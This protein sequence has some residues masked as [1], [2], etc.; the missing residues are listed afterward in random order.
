[1]YCTKKV[2]PEIK[3]ILNL[4]LSLFPVISKLYSY[5]ISSI[6]LTHLSLYLLCVVEHNESKTV[7]VVCNLWLD[8]K[9]IPDF[10]SF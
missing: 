10:Q 1:M 3:I 8:K 7:K 2:T 6:S 5:I 9:K 4:V